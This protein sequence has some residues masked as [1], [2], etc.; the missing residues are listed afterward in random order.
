[1]FFKAWIFLWLNALDA[2][3]LNTA[4]FCDVSESD[5][6]CVVNTLKDFSRDYWGSDR[7][8]GHALRITNT[9]HIR[10]RG[11][12]VT[13]RLHLTLNSHL[14]IEQGGILSLYVY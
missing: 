9:G 14:H 4:E 5:G 10:F 1:M 7:L 3:D 12:G 6:T 2:L 11:T 8:Q 13:A